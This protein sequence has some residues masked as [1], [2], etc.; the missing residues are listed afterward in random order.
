MAEEGA[1]RPGRLRL[2]TCIT[3]DIG[4]PTQAVLDGVVAETVG[5]LIVFDQAVI[6]EAAHIG[7]GL[8]TVRGE[9]AAKEEYRAVQRNVTPVNFRSLLTLAS[10]AR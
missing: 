5:E 9:C 1:E 7:H 3:Y 6:I 4:A 10:A 2:G 8:P